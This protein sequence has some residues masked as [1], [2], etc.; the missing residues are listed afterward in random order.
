MDNLKLLRNLNENIDAATRT[1]FGPG[2]YKHAI[3]RRFPMGAKRGFLPII[4]EDYTYTMDIMFITVVLQ[5]E[6]NSKRNW[7][8]KTSGR[9]VSWG[10]L[11]EGDDPYIIGGLVLIETTTRKIFFY[12]LHTKDPREVLFC[13]KRFLMD[14]D[15]KIV[16][17]ISDKGEE[18]RL[19]KQYNKKEEVVQ[20]LTS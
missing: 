5:E 20:A 12:K 7:S 8:R 6:S 11:E 4:A 3:D 13:F 16:R 19:I 18:Y 14:V 10:P 17:L 9:L 2:V 1:E 15:G